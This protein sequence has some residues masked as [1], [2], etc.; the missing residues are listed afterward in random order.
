MEDF[1]NNFDLCKSESV[2]RKDHE[3]NSN[4]KKSLVDFMFNKN[5]SCEEF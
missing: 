4:I 3:E 2:D 5:C 1:Q